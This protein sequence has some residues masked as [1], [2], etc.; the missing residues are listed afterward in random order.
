MPTADLSSWHSLY[1]DSSPRIGDIIQK[2]APFLKMYSEYVKN[3]D[4]AVELIT[5]WSEKSLA[6]QEVIS[7][8][9]VHWSLYA[10]P[11]SPNLVLTRKTFWDKGVCIYKSNLDML[12]TRQSINMAPLPYSSFSSPILNSS[13]VDVLHSSSLLGYLSPMCFLGLLVQLSPKTSLFTHIC[14]IFK[15]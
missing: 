15:Q 11:F 7:R 5:T 10:G 13:K 8:I 6:F 2:V 4:K 14:T 12:V 1:R 3:F 9:Q